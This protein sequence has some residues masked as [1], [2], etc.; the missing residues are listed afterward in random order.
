MTF[1]ISI[2]VEYSVFF[3]FLFFALSFLFSYL[4]YRNHSS[5]LDIPKYLKLLLFFLRFSTFFLLFFLLLA[6]K[7][8]KNEK[9]KENPIVVFL[10]DNSSS[11]ISNNDSVYYQ[12][13][14]LN[15]IDSLLNVKNVNINLISFLVGDT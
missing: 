10:Q 11:I 12:T 1:L 8:K 14:Y 7:L 3:L 13:Q 9:I 4:L 15:F 2:I 5:L 6:P